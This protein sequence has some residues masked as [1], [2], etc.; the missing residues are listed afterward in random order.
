MALWE[1]I[2]LAIALAMDAFSAAICKGLTLQKMDYKK[3]LLV[4]LY[5]G[6]FQGLMP[7]I[8]YFVGSAF[9]I[10]IESFDH[11]IAFAL[12]V[13]IG[14]NMIK[15]SFSKEEHDG[16]FS[17]KALIVLAI[18]TS[19]DSLTVGVSFSV[20]KP[21]IGIYISVL[22]IGVV[23]FVLSTLGVKI[24]NVFGS[25]FKQPAEITGGIILILIGIKILLEHL[26]VIS[27]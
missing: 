20:T 10:Y 21:L 13:F 6:L 15:E 23:T 17:F 27:F 4:G 18:A 2:L 19:I 14:I 11:W 25:R 26:G 1:V 3:A 12:L 24:G 7:L 8:G 5:F 16:D 22:I 9:S